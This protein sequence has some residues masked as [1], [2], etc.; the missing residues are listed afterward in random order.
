V[1]A[2]WR[3]LFRWEQ[4]ILSFNWHWKMSGSSKWQLGI[5]LCSFLSTTRNRSL[6]HT[7]NLGLSPDTLRSDTGLFV[8]IRCHPSEFAVPL[9][10]L[11]LRQARYTEAL[12]ELSLT[13]AGAIIH[14]ENFPG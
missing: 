4:A 8:F 13:Q 2:F 10:R 6:N 7:D 14:R 11:S 1:F 5:A 12:G 3:S 9:I